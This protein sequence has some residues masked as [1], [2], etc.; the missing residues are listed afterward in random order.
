M[1]DRVAPQ[2]RFVPK[3]E[4]SQA[5]HNVDYYRALS[6]HR[7]WSIGKDSVSLGEAYRAWRDYVEGAV[8]SVPVNSSTKPL[9]DNAK[10]YYRQVQGSMLNQSKQ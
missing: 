3:T 5:V 2:V 8:K 10:I 7:L 9:A 4:Y 1:F 6:R